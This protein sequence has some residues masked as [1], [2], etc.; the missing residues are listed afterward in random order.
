G[1]DRHPALPNG[2]SARA[3]QVN[4]LSAR[5]ENLNLGAVNADRGIPNT[6][7][8]V[9]TR[10]GRVR[11]VKLAQ[12]AQNVSRTRTDGRRQH[13]FRAVN[14]GEYESRVNACAT[15]AQNVC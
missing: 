12:I 4:L 13:V 1:V 6:G 2:G 7:H 15:R 3:Q 8:T 14:S 11:L 10:D 5:F 9:L